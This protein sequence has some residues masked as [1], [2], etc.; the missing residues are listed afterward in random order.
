MP[1]AVL[2]EPLWRCV[3]DL[4]PVGA[5]PALRLQGDGHETTRNSTAPHAAKL[6]EHGCK[7]LWGD[8]AIGIEDDVTQLS[9][10]DGDVNVDAEPAAV[11]D[12]GWPEET[13]RGGGDQRFLRTLG[14]CTPERE[15]VVVVMIGGRDEG[16]LVADE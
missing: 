1:G 3:N 15:A 2:F 9:P 11:A 8:G 16:F 13:L 6:P 7:A 12:V 5:R 14:R 10:V 4:F